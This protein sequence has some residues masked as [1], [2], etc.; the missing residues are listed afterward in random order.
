MCNIICNTLTYGNLQQAKKCLTFIGC[1]L[2]LTKAD[3]FTS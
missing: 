1:F 2:M 3:R